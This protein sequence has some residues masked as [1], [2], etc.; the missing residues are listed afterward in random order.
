MKKEIFKYY[1]FACLVILFS[2][3]ACTKDFD[4]LNTNPSSLAVDKFNPN[5]LLTSAQLAFSGSSDR[6]FDTWRSNIQNTSS[7]MQHFASIGAVADHPGDK[8][9]YVEDYN[10]SVWGDPANGAFL[11]QIKPITEALMLTKDSS[12][13]K[14]LYQITRI[15]RAIMLQ[16][17]TDLYG[18][19]P[20]VHAGTG[21]HSSVYFPKYDKQQ[22]IYDDILKEI[23]QAT[24]AL[25]PAGDKPSGDIFFDGNIEKW[26]RFGNSLLLRAGMRLTKVDPEKAKTIVAKVLDK[27]MQSNA[28]IAKVIHT[29]GDDRVTANR[30][31]QCFGFSD[32]ND[33]V[34]YSK[35]FIDFLR[36]NADPRL[37]VLA[38]VLNGTVEIRELN[39][40]KGMSNGY[41]RLPGQNNID[42]APGHT[43][44]TGAKEYSRP[45]SL[46][47]KQT[48]PTLVF[49][50]ALSELLL[51]DA[52]QRWGVGGNAETHYNNG[53]KAAMQQ[54]SL[55]DSEA[56]VSDAAVAAYLTAH[57]YDPAKGLEMINKQ[58]WAATLFDGYEAWSNWRRTDFPVLT[59]VDY[60]NN[61]TSGTIPRRFT[62]PTREAGTNP[63]NYKA[64]RAGVPGGDKMTS[65]V[66]WDKN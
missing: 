40:Q 60:P 27:T 6:A 46:L 39:K 55:F 44:G 42:K 54:Y 10:A 66:W 4:E 26:K 3:T 63:V 21:F 38:M 45:S 52:A 30:L 37:G 33:D 20:Y 59:P 58:I 25:D 53:V 32:F 65:R 22:L 19:V 35:T 13:L 7:F 14:N 16:R 17:I 24:N 41:D 23:E 57:P 49:T 11:E 64:A 5:Y 31:S 43:A 61:A 34:R 48:S 50:Y 15:M 28:D 2:I 51:A 1:R 12:A 56:A 9:I 62:Y 47:I 36:S 29:S 8:Y 18:D